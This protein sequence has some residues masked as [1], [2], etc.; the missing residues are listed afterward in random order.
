M[1]LPHSMKSR[2]RTVW[3][4]ISD[5]TVA[6]ENS[7]N[8]VSFHCFH[9]YYIGIVIWSS[10]LWNSELCSLI[11]QLS[12]VRYKRCLRLF[13]SMN[14]TIGLILTEVSFHFELQLNYKRGRQK[15]LLEIILAMAKEESVHKSKGQPDDSQMK[16]ITNG[17]PG[18]DH[19]NITLY[20]S[21]NRKN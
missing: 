19:Q 1:L 5:I 10:I 15:L 21:T 13:C 18:Y 20:K 14:F 12:H 4:N 16:Y 6:P 3:G 17:H 11:L 8:Q 9:L 2:Q 7:T